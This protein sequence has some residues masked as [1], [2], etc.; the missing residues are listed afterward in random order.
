M[1]MNL[2][3]GGTEREESSNLVYCSINTNLN[4]ENALKFVHLLLKY[5]A[6][7][8]SMPNL[9]LFIMLQIT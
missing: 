6:S 2:S 1:L 8:V 4:I 5:S 7:T 9:N 3:A